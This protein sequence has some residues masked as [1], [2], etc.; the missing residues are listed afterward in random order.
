MNQHHKPEEMGE[1]SGDVAM[2]DRP[3]VHP[4]D[5]TISSEKLDTERQQN[6]EGNIPCEEKCGVESDH[7][8]AQ[9]RTEQKD[10][11]EVKRTVNKRFACTECGYRAAKKSV[12]IKHTRK[13]T[14]EKPYKCDQCDYSAAQKVH[15]DRHVTK[16]KGEKPFMCGECGYRTTD[17]LSLSEH[18]SRHTGEK[19]Y[20]CDQCD[21]SAIRKVY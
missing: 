14:G 6:E 19:P 20:K 1:R 15:L 12:L 5:E 9:G 11:P 10:R 16:H 4:E 21:Y 8:P 2:D 17:R 7:P 3:A 18:M 13:H